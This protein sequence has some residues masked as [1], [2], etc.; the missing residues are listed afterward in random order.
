MFG[1]DTANDDLITGRLVAINLTPKAR[2]VATVSA[3][4]DPAAT[5]G[6]GSQRRIAANPLVVG[7]LQ[8][9][10]SVGIGTAAHTHI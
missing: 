9:A 1:T 10:G 2:V 4:K 8:D 3:N 6:V 5:G 7:R